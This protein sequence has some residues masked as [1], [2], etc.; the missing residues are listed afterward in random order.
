MRSIRPASIPPVA[1]MKHLRTA[2]RDG[3]AALVALVFVLPVLWAF[4]CAAK[5]H[6]QLLVHPWAVPSPVQ[7]DTWRQLWQNMR[8]G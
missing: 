2:I 7:A 1:N 4:A 5:A 6:N 3:P 8:A